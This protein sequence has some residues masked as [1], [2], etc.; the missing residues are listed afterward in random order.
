M[1]NY[2]NALLEKISKIVDMNEYEIILSAPWNPIEDSPVIFIELM[3]ILKELNVQINAIDLEML[4]YYC[5][6]DESICFQTKVCYTCNVR[7]LINYLVKN[8][9]YKI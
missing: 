9:F 8:G 7:N 3:I 5:V 6:A 4:K 1:D 2:M